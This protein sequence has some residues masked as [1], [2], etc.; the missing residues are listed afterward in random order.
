MPLAA[1]LRHSSYSAVNAGAT[2]L[3]GEVEGLRGSGVSR[4]RR[5]GVVIGVGVGLQESGRAIDMES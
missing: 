4:W 5:S 3:L 2:V 1:K